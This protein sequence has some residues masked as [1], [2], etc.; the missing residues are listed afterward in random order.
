MAIKINEAEPEDS[1][2]RYVMDTTSIG[3]EVFYVRPHW[4]KNHSEYLT[5][6]EGRAE[7]TLDGEKVILQAG[8]PAVRVPRRVVHS[9]RGFEGERLV[10]RESADPAG[11]YKALF[12]NDLLSTGRLSGF[13]YILRAFYDWDTYIPLHLYFRVFDEVFI[14]IFGGIAHLFAPKKLEKL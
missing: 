10:L 14:T 11:I 4:H 12:F 6:L 9:M 2:G 13:W 8:D 7:V 5:V 1:V 3:E